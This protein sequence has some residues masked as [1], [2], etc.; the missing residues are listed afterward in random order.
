MT[1]QTSPPSQTSE[2][3]DSYWQGTGDIGAFTSGGASHP[4]IRA[5]WVEYFKSVQKKFNQ[6]KIIDIASG[7]GA[8]IECALSVF[9]GQKESISSLDISASAIDNIQKRF[10]DV[11]GIVSDAGALSKDI[12]S[13]DIVT[14]QFGIEYAGF[15]AI[16]ESAKLVADKGQLAFL[17]HYESGSIHQEC[18]QSLAAIVK[19]RRI[20]FIPLAIEMFDAGFKAIRGAD[21]SIYENAA[22]KLAPA[23]GELEAIMKEYGTHVAG[24]TIVRLYNDVA[25]VHQRIQHYE[26]N[27]VL[28][29]LKKID[30]E[31]DAYISRMDSMCDSAITKDDFHK[32]ESK[33]KEKGFEI[34][35][36]DAFYVKGIASPMAWV[37]IANKV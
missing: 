7:N 1:D 32:I 4:A 36:A 20:K 33:L 21:R 11:K 22:R 17:M 34:V 26:P 30:S 6:P 10:P 35:T 13:F 25:N 3:W 24:D 29:W 18:Q 12:G 16:S 5:F 37:L 2:S 15:D 8:V 9:A 14:S 27:D 28:N 23:L 19:L 31:L